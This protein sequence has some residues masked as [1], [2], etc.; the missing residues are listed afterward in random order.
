MKFDILSEYDLNNRFKSEI[1][2]YSRS[3]L[4]R[5]R[6]FIQ[7]PQSDS[8]QLPTQTTTGSLFSLRIQYDHDAGI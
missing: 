2:F 3:S 4:L 6:S 1:H 7:N 5:R 8:S